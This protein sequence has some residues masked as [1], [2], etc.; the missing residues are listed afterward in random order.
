VLISEIRGKQM[1]IKQIAIIEDEM[2]HAKLIGFNLE[3]KGYK[4]EHFSKIEDFIRL[5][6]AI[7]FDLILISAQLYE[8][9]LQ[10]CHKVKEN[11]ISIPILLLTTSVIDNTCCVDGV[12]YLFKPFNIKELLDKVKELLHTNK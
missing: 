2:N 7:S 4:T 12:E 1:S 6:Y 8:D 5:D 9:G 11:D 3:K 10:L